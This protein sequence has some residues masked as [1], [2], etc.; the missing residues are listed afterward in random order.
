[1]TSQRSGRDPPNGKLID[2]IRWFVDAQIPDDDYVIYVEVGIEGDFNAYWPSGTRDGG[3]PRRVGI[4]WAKI[5][6]DS[7]ASS[8]KCRSG[9]TRAVDFDDE[10]LR[11]IYGDFRAKTA[12]SI[13]LTDDQPKRRIGCRSA[14]DEH[15]RQRDLARQGVGVA[16]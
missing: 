9:S 14:G 13:R 2:P 7:R 8:T 16:V 6:M 12:S 5:R 11:W 3:A 1:M 10:G 4:T 15:R